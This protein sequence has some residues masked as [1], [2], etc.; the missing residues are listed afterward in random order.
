MLS[1]VVGINLS[2]CNH[3]R[4]GNLHSVLRG[5]NYVFLVRELMKSIKETKNNH[6]VVFSVIKI[7]L[8]L[9]K[10]SQTTYRYTLQTY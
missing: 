2:G 6:K 1:I 8:H 9:E 5:P 7:S 10:K 4:S 3:S